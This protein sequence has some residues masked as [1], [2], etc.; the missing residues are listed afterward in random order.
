MKWVQAVEYGMEWVQALEYGME[1]Y[2]QLSMY[3][4]GTSS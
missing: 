1:W 4:V 2:K 3:G